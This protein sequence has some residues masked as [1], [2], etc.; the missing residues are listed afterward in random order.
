MSKSELLL[1]RA[2]IG[3]AGFYA[4][5]FVGLVVI[6]IFV[7]LSDGSLDIAK[8]MFQALIVLITTQSTY[9]F[10]R[11]RT[12]TPPPHPDPNGDPS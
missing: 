11:Q 10:A 4:V 5:A 2:Q 9:F 12:T 8:D 1:A 3:L 6:I 7:P